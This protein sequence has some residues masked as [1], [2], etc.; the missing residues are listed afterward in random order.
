MTV[1]NGPAPVSISTPTPSSPRASP[2]SFAAVAR[3]CVNPLANMRQKALEAQVDDLNS[4]LAEAFKVQ[5]KLKEQNI[6]FEEDLKKTQ[7]ENDDLRRAGVSFR[8]TAV[9]KVKSRFS[10][11]FPDALAESCQTVS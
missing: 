1:S 5:E 4:Q 8:R 10:N 2:I 11:G 6:A 3:W 9:W 7:A